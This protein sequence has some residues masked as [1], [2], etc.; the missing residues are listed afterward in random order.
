MQLWLLA[1]SSAI[2]VLLQQLPHQRHLVLDSH[3]LEF[4]L[5]EDAV[6][7]S[8]VKKANNCSDG[9]YDKRIQKCHCH[10]GSSLSIETGRCEKLDVQQA[11]MRARCHIDEILD[12]HGSCV[13]LSADWLSAYGLS[14][15][16]RQKPRDMAPDEDSQQVGPPRIRTEMIGSEESQDPVERAAR[17]LSMGRHDH[18]YVM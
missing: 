10:R 7:P 16:T 1:F 3:E 11:R 4:E 9:Y 18:P 5:I 6:P 15:G 17:A 8:Q 12:E 2:P 13:K 14:S